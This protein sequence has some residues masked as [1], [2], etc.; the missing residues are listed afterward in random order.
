MTVIYLYLLRGIYREGR[1]KNIGET[2]LE[3]GH[4]IAFLESEA[5]VS[6]FTSLRVQSKVKFPL[7]IHIQ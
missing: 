6:C 1:F 4:C 2:L 7:N 3:D 5:A